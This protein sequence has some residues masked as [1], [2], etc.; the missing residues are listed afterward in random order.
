MAKKT[1]RF[2]V[3]LSAALPLMFAAVAR[4]EPWRFAAMGDTRS[5]GGE[6]Q[7]N[8]GIV[9][10]I[11]GSIIADRVDLVLVT[12]DLVCSGSARA[13]DQWIRAVEPV[14]RAG[15][16]VYPVRGNHDLTGDPETWRAAF[17]GMIPSNGPAGELMM[18][19][20]VTNRDACFIMLDNYAVAGGVNVAWV[21]SVLMSNTLPHVFAVGHMPAFKVDH[22]DCL[23]DNRD[24]RD[25]FWRLLARHRAKAYFCGHDH[26]YSAI[27]LDD[28]DGDAT[29]DV[30]QL[31]VGS[32]GA[33]LY[34]GGD[35]DGD[36]G[37]WKPVNLW[38]A[39]EYGY[40]VVEIDGLSA[41]WTWKQRIG[42]GKFDVRHRAEFPAVKQIGPTP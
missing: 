36:N 26:F 30:H 28:G 8:T 11:V 38:F 15:V 31:I 6:T 5:S 1:I 41:R 40:V 9:A 20:V 17:G 16:A 42:Q 23:D 7:V 22:P 37:R 24:V 14:R 33:G 25:R 21:N 19:Y 10:D 18:T 32:G 29:N 27:R 4:G 2:A 12:G 34:S 35:F 3:L 13:F 39:K